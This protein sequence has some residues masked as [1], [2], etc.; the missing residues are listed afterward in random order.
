MTLP[1]F[2]STMFFEVSLIWLIDHF[3]IEDNRRLREHS[4]LEG[5]CMLGGDY[6]HILCF[7]MQGGSL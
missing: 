7:G 1:V 4:Q 6:T 2:V 3:R 5:R